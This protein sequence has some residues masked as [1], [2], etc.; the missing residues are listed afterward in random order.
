MC[1]VWISYPCF[2]HCHVFLLRGGILI[3]G[4]GRLIETG[5]SYLIKDEEWIGLCGSETVIVIIE[6]GQQKGTCRK[7]TLA[8]QEKLL[9]EQSKMKSSTDCIIM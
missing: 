1:G 9:R 6:Q 8:A 3:E 7:S 5:Y 2:Q 4:Q